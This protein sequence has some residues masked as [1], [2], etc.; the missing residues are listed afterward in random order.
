MELLN[1][2]E[3]AAVAGVSDR[4]L[5]KWTAAGR[6][7][8]HVGA[9]G[10]P[11]YDRQQLAALTGTASGTPPEPIGTQAELFRNEPERTGTS[12]GIDSASFVTPYAARWAA[13]LEREERHLAELAGVRQQLQQL[14]AEQA[15]LAVEVG[16]LRAVRDERDR[17]VSEVDRLHLALNREQES[18]LRL[19]ARLEESQ[20]ALRE[21][22]APRALPK[23]TRPWWR[24]WSV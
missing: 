13:A 1:Q 21:A 18:V 8:R 10:R 24:F 2:A 5:R 4:T 12:A 17:L 15:V 11:R 16:E 9:D 14:H 19:A 3:A 22:T 23:P 20:L 6:L 7:T